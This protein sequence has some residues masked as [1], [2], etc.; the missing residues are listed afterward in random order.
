MVAPPGSPL[1][2]V[3]V[4]CRNEAAYIGPCLD[5]ILAS[6]YPVERMEVLVADGMSDDGTTDIVRRYAERWPAIRLVPNPEG[7]AP[8]GLN[9]AIRQA[10]GEVIVRMDAH[11]VYPRNYL[12]LLV[13]AL[14]ESGADNVGGV[15]ETLP[16]NPGATAR[17]IAIGVAHPLGVG[18]SYFR[19][20]T[21]ARRWVDTVPFGCYRRA[22]FDRVGLFDEALVRNQDDEFNFRLVARGGRIL[23]LPEVVSQYFAR[24]TLGQTSRMFYQ[25]GYFKP[26]VARKVGR[27]MTLRQL[28]PALFV[29]SLVVGA[30]LALVFDWARVGLALLVAVYASIVVFASA[31]AIPAH[32]VRCASV[33]AGVF[34]LLHFSYGVGFLRGLV[35]HFARGRSSA[36]R[37]STVPLSR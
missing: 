27:V 24:A 4:P 35:D 21:T 31:R 18:N 14:Q 29:L 5:S 19:I 15:I 13:T 8:T 10:T 17:A 1:I 3:V 16:A 20:G 6:E 34:P 25:Y 32:G 7:I 28:V 30:A 26:L 11:V 23:L 22:V 36:T 12:P 2:T 37:P 9:R 33:L